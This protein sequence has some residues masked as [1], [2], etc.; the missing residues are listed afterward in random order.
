[1][2]RTRTPGE[3]PQ[4]RPCRR[5]PAAA[6]DSPGTGR[7]V[8]AIASKG[9]PMRARLAPVLLALACL[10]L[11]LRASAPA[12]APQPAAGDARRAAIQGQLRHG[13]WA[14]ALA[15]VQGEI[16]RALQPGEGA[17]PLADLAAWKAVAEVGLGRE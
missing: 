10:A 15:A 12:A 2:L 17:L 4:R 16:N 1:M 3:T 8:P 13:D 14:P 5:R 7:Q 9:A 6:A 11:P